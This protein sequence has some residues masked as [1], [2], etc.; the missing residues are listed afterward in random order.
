LK[1][2]TN[3]SNF[4]PP[5]YPRVDIGPEN[6]LQIERDGTAILE[7]NVDAKPKVTSV[8]WYRD[9]RFISTS[10]THTIHRVT[11]QDS[12]KY[13]CNADNGLGRTGEKEVV[14]DV[15]YSPIVVIETKTREAVEHE[16]VSIRCNVSSNPPP[17]QVE[18]L[19]EGNPDFRYT[20]EVLTL[21]DVKAEHAGTYV[22]RGINI[23]KP[24]GGKSVER[25][26]NTTVALLIR[27]RP[28]KAIITPN[29]PVVHVGNAVTLTCSASPPGWPVPQ[30]KWYRDVEGELTSTN[31]LSQGSQYVIPRAHLGTEGTYRCIASNE[32]GHGEEAKIQLEV[33]QPPQ[34]LAKLQQHITRRVGDS[35]YS[36]TC[37]AKGKPKPS[38][39]W[40]KDGRELSLEQGLFEIDTNPI[41]GP[42][43]M[44]TVQST[45]R[46]VG[47]QR[48]GGNQ[49]IPNDRGLFSCLYENEVNS[50]NSTM[51]LRIEHEPIILHQYNKVAFDLRETAEVICKVQAYPKPE[52]QWQFGTNTAPLSMSSD[53]HYEISTTTDNNDVY[54]SI[55]RVNN[56]RHKDYGDYICRVANT[57]DTIR[58]KITL[59]QKGPPEKPANLQVAEVGPN[60]ITLSWDP[61]FDG[62]LTNTKYFVLYRRI[63]LPMNE[64]V[65]G[66]CGFQS[67]SSTEWSEF[68]CHRDVPC[69]IT[70]LD[71]HQSYE[72]KVSRILKLL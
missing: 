22:C 56:L 4:S 34:F 29:K 45:L 68:D 54:T 53:G 64:Q 65:N 40:L 50:A 35:D 52:F 7:C 18:W 15:L 37:S 24:Y 39:R 32:M 61:G 72:F 5:D 16:S 46:L 10:F 26:G 6:P 11:V 63:A 51:H 13:V 48:P 60:Y 3:K 23:M 1:K 49:L 31:V 69:N 17:I 21:T 25:V 36:V 14:L 70:P 67:V 2:K 20:G 44:V 9:G 58:A 8:S 19:K 38:V 62:G 43:G 59:Q 28:G 66:D 30:Y 12:G 42:N 33:H 55:L 41:E 57:L 47:K 71:Q 27:H